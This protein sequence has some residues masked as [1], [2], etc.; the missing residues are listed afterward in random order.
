MSAEI[1]GDANMWGFTI[2]RASHEDYQPSW[3]P[4]GTP[5]GTVEDAPGFDL[6]STLNQFFEVYPSS[7][8]GST[9]LRNADLDFTSIQ[10][11][12]RVQKPT[13]PRRRGASSSGGGYEV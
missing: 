9:V 4:T 3:L 1:R 5:S 11:Q 2:Y 10:D 13:L 6:E 8:P 12:G 7:V